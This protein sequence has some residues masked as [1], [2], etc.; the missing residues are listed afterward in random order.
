[1]EVKN[2]VAVGS[3]KLMPPSIAM[4]SGVTSDHV[5][6]VLTIVYLTVLIGHQLW[7]WKRE[8]SRG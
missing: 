5:I 2:E 8:A 3:L 4:W 7:K 6:A 1:M